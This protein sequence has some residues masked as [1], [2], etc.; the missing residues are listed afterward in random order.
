MSI[1]PILM[2]GQER[3]LSRFSQ[4][5]RK[6]ILI[7]IAETYIAKYA[8]NYL[9]YTDHTPVIE[10]HVVTEKEATR[11]LP[12]GKVRYFVNYPTSSDLSL[13]HRDIHSYIIRIYIWEDIGLIE[14]VMVN[15]FGFVGPE[16][17]DL[18]TEIKDDDYIFLLP[19]KK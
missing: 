15:G 18:N 3:D 1:C 10:R 14:S 11:D 16:G 17:F 6:S 7:S 2:N 5:E 19:S 12:V 4:T 13:T 8:P 9:S